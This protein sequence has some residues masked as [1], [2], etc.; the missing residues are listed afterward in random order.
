MTAF[1]VDVVRRVHHTH[2]VTTRVVAESWLRCGPW[3]VTRHDIV[4]VDGHYRVA[5]L[6]ALVER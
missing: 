5:R 4:M 2:M 1:C 6:A 3:T